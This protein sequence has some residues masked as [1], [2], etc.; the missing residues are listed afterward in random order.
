MPQYSDDLFL[1][2]A[3][4]FMGT[5]LRDASATFTG[6][7]GVDTWNAVSD[8]TNVYGIAHTNQPSVDGLEITCNVI[9][10]GNTCANYPVISTIYNHG[11]FQPNLVINGGQ[12]C[13]AL[14]NNISN[15]GLIPT[16]LILTS[17]YLMNNF[18]MSKLIGFNSNILPM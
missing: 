3:Q 11:S 9:S 17:K 16:Y 7:S 12:Y 5:G 8:G 10:T 15:V 14:N 6:S 4:T 2:S 13:K 18:N 1:G